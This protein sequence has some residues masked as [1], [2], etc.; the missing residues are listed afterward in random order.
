MQER[1]RR[2]GTQKKTSNTFCRFLATLRRVSNLRRTTHRQIQLSS[3]LPGIFLSRCRRKGDRRMIRGNRRVG[4][5]SA[6]DLLVQNLRLLVLSS[7]QPPQVTLTMLHSNWLFCHPNLKAWT[8]LLGLTQN[9]DISYGL[10]LVA[11]IFQ[12][13]SQELSLLLRTR[14]LN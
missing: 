4:M 2:M 10:S 7:F 13:I 8:S 6:P 9:T 3:K 11:Q 14:N 1:T 5:R 12:G